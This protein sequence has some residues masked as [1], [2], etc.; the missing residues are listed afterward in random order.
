MLDFRFT[1]G[2]E[3]NNNDNNN[4]NNTLNSKLLIHLS[5]DTLKNQYFYLFRVFLAT[6]WVELPNVAKCQVISRKL[7]SSESTG[8]VWTPLDILFSID[9]EEV[10]SRV[11][12][13]LSAATITHNLPIAEA[14][15]NTKPK[16]W[17]T[18]SVSHTRRGY[19]SYIGS[20]PCHLLCCKIVLYVFSFF[21]RWYR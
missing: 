17:V 21:M 14:L 11:K 7:S 18:C 13:F 20:L 1:K 12:T 3:I 2:I 5:N 16:G 10:S 9:F 19:L 6:F 15:V 4:N 8:S